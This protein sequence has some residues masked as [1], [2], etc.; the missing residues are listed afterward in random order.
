MN[1]LLFFQNYLRFVGFQLLE[2]LI[3]LTDQLIGHW[4]I[5]QHFKQLIASYLEWN[6]HEILPIPALKK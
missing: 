1:D 2:E 6:L 5:T 3:L 4:N